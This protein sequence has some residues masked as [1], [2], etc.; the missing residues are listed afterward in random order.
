MKPKGKQL[1][2]DDMPRAGRAAED[3]VYDAIRESILEH[4]LAPGTK[5]TETGLASIF[6]ASRSA[7]RAALSR[8]GNDRI[9]ELRPN[10]GAVVAE[11]R[12]EEAEELFE[13]RRAIESAIVSGVA[14]RMTPGL[15]AD[16]RDHVAREKAA[17]LDGDLRMAQRLSRQFHVELARASGNSYLLRFLELLIFRQPLLVLAHAGNRLH[18]CGAHEHEAVVERLAEGDAEGALA[19]MLAHFDSL[20]VQFDKGARESGASL[21][22]ALARLARHS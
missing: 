3:R 21:P 12:L 18:Y 11:P 6:G 22:E 10:R 19:V 17:Y 13:A 20:R 2:A 15:L 9:V 16:L 7:V 1:H 14:R 5:L 4:G 8:L